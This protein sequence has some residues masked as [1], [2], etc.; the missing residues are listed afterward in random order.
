MTT[1]NYLAEQVIEVSPDPCGSG[2]TTWGIETMAATPSLTIYAVDRIKEMEDRADAIRK[3]ARR[4]GTM[5]T[6]R[7]LNSEDGVSVSREFPAEIAA[8][9]NLTHVVLIITHA[10]LRLVDHAD[11]EGWNLIIDEDPKLWVYDNIDTGQVSR[12]TWESLYNLSAPTHDGYSVISLKADA[13]SYQEMVRDTLTRAIAP[14][15]NRVKASGL[16]DDQTLRQGSVIVKLTD[17]DDLTE[18]L[19]WFTIWDLR[20]LRRY[21]RVVILANSF[22]ELLTARLIRL[23]FPEIELRPIAITRSQPWA[24]RAVHINYVAD[25]HTITVNHLRNTDEGRQIVADWA[26]WVR[27]RVRGPHYW[28]TNKDFAVPTAPDAVIPGERITSKIAG[29]NRF[30]DYHECSV[31]YAAK[32]SPIESR[33]FADL[34]GNQI[35]RE[36]VRRDREFEDLIQIVFRSSLRKPEST[37]T[38]TLNVY[39]SEQAEFIRDYFEAARF[40]FAI[41]LNHHD[42]GARKTVRKRGPK[43]AGAVPLAA[44]ERTRRSRANAKAKTAG[45]PLPY[46]KGGK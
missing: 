42:I 3:A 28:C 40:P 13:P 38:V 31:L 2:K 45:L 15:H 46:P 6:V 24:P 39:D 21:N 29:T 23:R 37:E 4:L 43:M 32:A 12:P 18:R 26:A 34:A 7:I 25:D 14:F 41:S 30:K 44:A 11:A 16:H 8:L 33:V 9:K 5:P 10:A 36:D 35:T 1:Q 20:V 22:F 19:T 27:S 17:W